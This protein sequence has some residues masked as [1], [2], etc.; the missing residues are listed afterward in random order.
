MILKIQG[1]FVNGRRV[2]FRTFFEGL[3]RMT[4]KPSFSRAKPHSKRVTAEGCFGE[5]MSHSYGEFA[6]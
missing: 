5:I 6:Y 4:Q 3:S 1:D 2:C